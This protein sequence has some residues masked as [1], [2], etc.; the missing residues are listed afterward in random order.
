MHRAD[1]APEHMPLGVQ[2]YQARAKII[3]RQREKKDVIMLF[4]QAS[5]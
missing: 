4:S 2:K 3:P 5:D 1:F